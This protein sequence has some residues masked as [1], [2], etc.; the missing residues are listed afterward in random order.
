MHRNNGRLPAKW[1]PRQD[2]ATGQGYTS[3]H[4]A[5][6]CCHR[7]IGVPELCSYP[8]RHG[9]EHVPANEDLPSCSCQLRVLGISGPVCPSDPGIGATALDKGRAILMN[10]IQGTKS[11][12]KTVPQ[13]L[14]GAALN[15]A[16]Q[17]VLSMLHAAHAD[18]HFADRCHISGSGF[19]DNEIAA[20]RGELAASA[21]QK[22]RTDQVPYLSK[23][24]PFSLRTSY[25]DEDYGLCTLRRM[26]HSHLHAWYVSHDKSEVRN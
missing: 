13:S 21:D 1:Q 23:M 9:R 15:A 25:N 11:T 18:D 7:D 17:L 24:P 16:K 14:A 22:N 5:Q 19:T 4:A 26:T 12:Q 6:G 8:Q 3:P 20:S 2:K 10:T